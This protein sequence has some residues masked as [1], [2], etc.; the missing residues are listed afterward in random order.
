MAVNWKNIS[1]VYQWSYFNHLCPCLLCGLDAGDGTGLCQACRRDLPWLNG[2][3]CRCG[4]PRRPGQACP[5]CLCQQAPIA[6]VRPCFHYCFPIDRLL[7]RYK[8]DSDL[9]CERV[10]GQLWRQQLP[11]P[12][13]AGALVPVP[14]HWRRHLQRG[15]N[16]ARQLAA[17]LASASGRPLWPVLGRRRWAPSQQRLGRQQR[18]RDTDERFVCRQPVSG[19]HLV[20]VD[21]V[22]TTG[23]TVSACA[24]ALHEAGAASVEVW[25]LART[26]PHAGGLTQVKASTS[27]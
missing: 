24:R 14:L 27:N 13:G 12:G 25:C 8:H 17:A 19:L 9:A 11:D 21:D 18:W 15:F 6:A 3:L 2:P 23:A 7:N 20:L 22:H 1:K 4:L 5:G 16:Q 10:L 26:L